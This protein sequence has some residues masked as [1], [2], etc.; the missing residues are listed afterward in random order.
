MNIE[1]IAEQMSR[2]GRRILAN[3]FRV[4]LPAIAL[5]V[6]LF[7][8]Y[9]ETWCQGYKPLRFAT[10]ARLAKCIT[11]H[12][13]I[14]AGAVLL[15]GGLGIVLGGELVEAYRCARSAKDMP[16]YRN[17]DVWTHLGR[18]G[19]MAVLATIGLLV[20]VYLGMWYGY[21]R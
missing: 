15:F 5:S 21:S 11:S 13:A 6:P 2:L 10:G 12:V 17:Y 7:A 18:L 16:W 20:A 14:W 8:L 9:L 3:R 1:L 4:G 19:G